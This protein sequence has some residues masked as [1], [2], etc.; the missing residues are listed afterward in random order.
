MSSSSLPSEVTRVVS[1]L[2]ED[3]GTPFTLSLAIRLRYEDWDGILE[4]TPDPRSYL[5]ASRY[6]RDAAGSAFLKKLKELPGSA[7]RQLAAIQKWWQGERECYLTNERLQPYLDENPHHEDRV[8]AIS[9]FLAETRKIVSDWIG[10]GPDFREE[11][12]F[13]PGATF[14]NRG[15]KTTVPDK[16]STDPSLTRD[17]IWNLPQWLG[18]QWGASVA[19]RHGELSFVP[20]NR[21]TTVPKTAKTD[22]SI[23]VEPSI[24][25]FYQLALG[26]ELRRRLARRPRIARSGDG[27]II[28]KDDGSAIWKQYAGWDLD[29]A[30]E[31]HRQVAATSSVTREFA[32]LDLS[33]ASD[34]VAR[35]LVRLLLPQR[36][37]EALDDLRSKKTLMTID[38]KTIPHKEG[39]Q[40]YLSVGQHWVVLEKFSSMGN[41]F[42]FE[43]ETIIFGAIACSIARNCGGLGLLGVDV[44]VFGDDIIVKNDVVHPLKSALGFL[45]FTLNEEKS[46]FDVVPFR[47][48]CGGDFFAGKPVRPYYLKELPNGPQDYIALANGLSHLAERLALTGFA[49]GRRA[50]FATLDCIPTRIRSCRG[51]KD[52][53]DIVIYDSEERWTWRRRSGIRYIRALKPDRMRVIP[54]D[55]F[56]AQ[57]VLA[58]ATYGTGNYGTPEKGVLR[59]EGVIPRDG[60]LSYRVGWVPWS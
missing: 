14:S 39:Q 23:A 52:L 3:L 56:D 17:A 21:F 41:G 26:R 38:E 60:L 1:L 42:T 34:T 28:R 22:R 4:V 50:W 40:S 43:L 6:A 25:V 18:T 33:N 27:S 46:F 5:D 24:N 36:W 55:L 30:Q 44:F 58:C 32:T 11:G 20:G 45:G 47:E 13:G 15:G 37:Y 29:S 59:R 12:R 16:M 8:A 48:S 35:N 49:L 10:Y 2:L 53:G 54:F 7:D 31:V 57:V 19:Q 9:A 51:P